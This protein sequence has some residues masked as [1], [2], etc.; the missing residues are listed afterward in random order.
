MQEPCKDCT[1]NNP[2]NPIYSRATPDLN[3]NC[4]KCNGKDTVF[5]PPCSCPPVGGWTITE[6]LDIPAMLADQAGQ[7]GGI[8]IRVVDASGDPAIDAGYAYYE[9]LGTTIG[10]ITDY[11]IIGAQQWGLKAVAGIYADVAT[12]FAD[13]VSQVSQMA[14]RVDDASGDPDISSGY[15]YYEYLGTTT[16]DITDYKKI[17]SQ[18]AGTLNNGA[19]TTW[20]GTTKGVDLGGGTDIEGSKSVGLSKTIPYDFRIEELQDNSLDKFR[21]KIRLDGAYGFQLGRSR[22]FTGKRRT[23]IIEAWRDP[24]GGDVMDFY[25]YNPDDLKHGGM[26]VTDQG[27]VEFGELWSNGDTGRFYGIS[28]KA[29]YSSI[30]WAAN[31]AGN[32]LMI[33]HQKRVQ[34]MIDA[35]AGGGVAGSYADT[36]A[37]VADQGNQTSGAIYRVVDAGDGAIGIYSAG[38]AYFEYLGTTVGDMTDYAIIGAEEW[39]RPAVANLYGDL[40]SLIAAQVAGDIDQNYLYYVL[41]ASGF[42]GIDAGYAFVMYKGT[43]AGDETDYEIVGCKQ[44]IVWVDN[45]WKTLSGT[46]QYRRDNS[47][48]VHMKGKTTS[49]SGTFGTLDAGY[50]PGAGIEW[51]TWL[52][53]SI[54]DSGSTP[55]SCAIVEKST[56]INTTG[57]VVITAHTSGGTGQDIFFDNIR[58]LAEN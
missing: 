1:Q 15:A 16:G 33:P 31:L 57:T 24:L 19:G 36:A 48:Y 25:S 13:Q 46:V 38:Y 30:D 2:V 47:G 9:Y 18:E 4:E 8:I 28:Y 52:D 54:L 51:P 21:T 56:K 20:N 43:A 40:A 41:D 26:R 53:V 5:V 11:K 55:F 32:G 37:L 49:D 39:Q 34:E 58:F 35:V 44:G 45:A 42:T 12:M 22:H 3:E 14:Y 50:R 7:T 27:T 17:S 23:F 10:D 6:Y 29:D